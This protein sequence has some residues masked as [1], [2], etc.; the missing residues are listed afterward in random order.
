[1]RL[2]GLDDK[3]GWKTSEKTVS[4]SL[5]PARGLLRTFAGDVADACYTSRHDELA[6]GKYG[7]L[8]A[9]VFVT[10]RGTPK[11]RIRGSVLAIE[12]ERPDGAPVLVVRANNPQESF[13]QRV[14]PA[15]LVELTLGEMRKLGERLGVEEVVVPRDPAS[16]SSSNRPAVSKHYRRRYAGSARVAL[17]KAEETEFNGYPNWNAAGHHPV[18]SIGLPES[19]RVREDSG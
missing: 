12:A 6:E 10:G 8:T 14:D 1:M 17:K 7:K 4:V 3:Y 2:E 9:Y 16:T 13:I 11:E 18:V 5:V 15:A 19:A